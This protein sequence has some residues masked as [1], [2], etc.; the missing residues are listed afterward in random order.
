MHQLENA[1]ADAW[2][3]S[4]WADVTALVAVSGGADSVALLR[5]VAAVRRPG[6][7]RVVVAHFNHGWR[8]AASD[9]DEVFVRHLA[10]DL[11]WQF[12]CG[13]AAALAGSIELPTSRSEASARRQRY[14]FLRHTAERVGARY[15]ALAHT[16][17]DQIETIL[18]RLLRGT[19]IA[20]LAGIP[21]V[22]RLSEATSIVRPLLDVRRAVVLDYL[23][24]LGQSFSTD[25]TNESLAYTRNRLRH[26][27][28]PHLARRYNPRV[29]EALLRLGRQAEDLKPL[30][31]R[32]LEQATASCVVENSA[33][34]VRIA[35][36]GLR[37]FPPFIVRELFV[38]C[39]RSQHWPEGDMTAEH[40]DQLARLASIDNWPLAG[41]KLAS[42]EPRW[43]ITLPGAVRA[44][45]RGDEIVL[46]ATK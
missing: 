17:D 15:V 6:P 12:E 13:R 7:G 29:G 14:R 28:L 16:A 8:G 37:P 25:T 5:G 3:P 46:E 42:A 45:R 1:I 18:H 32:L 38:S 40:W 19:G 21:R 44:T 31:A 43:R 33:G 4:S 36:D 11:G 24:T 10:T 39:W 30:I 27:L 20:G 22:R 34:V 26:E 23:A 35:T 41:R 2:P 9:A